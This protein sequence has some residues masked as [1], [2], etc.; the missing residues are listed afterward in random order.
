MEKDI[1]FW[2][3]D[4][5]TFQNKIFNCYKCVHFLV[6]LKN[7]YRYIILRGGVGGGGLAYVVIRE[8][9]IILSTFLG[10]L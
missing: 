9:A 6:V 10:V 4:Q 3:K 7:I 1:H 5:E 8:C 2:N